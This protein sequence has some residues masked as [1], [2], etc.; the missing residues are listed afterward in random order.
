MR[1]TFPV[2]LAGENYIGAGKYFKLHPRSES[3]ILSTTDLTIVIKKRS[4][5]RVVILVET[6]VSISKVEFATNGPPSL[7]NFKKQHG[8][9]GRLP[10]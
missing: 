7:Q 9:E 8:E 6:I 4:Q 1:S 5:N 10:A 3:T 2:L